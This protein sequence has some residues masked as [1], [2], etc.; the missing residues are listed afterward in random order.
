VIFLDQNILDSDNSELPLIIFIENLLNKYYKTNS[1]LRDAKPITI[2]VDCDSKRRLEI[3]SSLI[4]NGIVF[5]DG[6][7]EI[8][9]SSTVF[10]N[11]PI[12]NKTTNGA[13]IL[14][15]SYVLKILSKET[16]ISHILNIHSPSTF[17]LFSK[18]DFL[19]RFPSGQSVDIRYC[20]NLKEV[21]YLLTP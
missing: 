9:F 13:K 10:N 19:L 3:K 15:S 21:H 2:I 18:Q 12:I 6:Y 4:D 7:E 11:E 8:K 17:L 14:K 5:N 1:S 20:E 16:F